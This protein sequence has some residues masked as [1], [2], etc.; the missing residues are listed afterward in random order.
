MEDLLRLAEDAA[1]FMDVEKIRVC[2]PPSAEEEDCLLLLDGIYEVP[3]PETWYSMRE[4]DHIGRTSP[5]KDGTPT[6]T[7]KS[8]SQSD[9]SGLAD[10]VVHS[11]PSL[12][13]NEFSDVQAFHECA[14]QKSTPVSPDVP[15]VCSKRLFTPADGELC[16]DSANSSAEAD[17]TIASPASPQN[18]SDPISEIRTVIDESNTANEDNQ[19]GIIYT[20]VSDSLVVL[21]PVINTDTPVPVLPNFEQ[22]QTEYHDRITWLSGSMPSIA[23]S[24]T[25]VV[26]YHVTQCFTVQENAAL[27]AAMVLSVQLGVPLIALV[28]YCVTCYCKLFL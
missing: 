14:N 23:S 20:K 17:H 28:S 15:F 19:D 1:F 12:T 16:M 7:S 27:R 2:F 25:N 13:G 10:N 3:S 8:F 24:H 11:T 21:P 9:S 5:L 26:Y 4:V 22:F 18:K 6:W